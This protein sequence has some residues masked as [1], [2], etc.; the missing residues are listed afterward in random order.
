MFAH[1]QVHG[2]WI[3]LTS[4]GPEP[5]C[6]QLTSLLTSFVDAAAAQTGAAGPAL[7]GRG[8]LATCLH[9]GLL[10]VFPGAQSSRE[11]S[12]RNVPRLPG[13]GVGVDHG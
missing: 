5:T 2:T 12:E 6:V 7:D 11:L 3:Q 13:R 9:R 1:G 4:H 8:A 10:H